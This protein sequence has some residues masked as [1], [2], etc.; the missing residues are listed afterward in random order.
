MEQK[1]RQNNQ[2]GIFKRIDLIMKNINCYSKCLTV[3][4]QW[5]LGVNLTGISEE[6]FF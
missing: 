3:V 4:F 1:L 5:D 2:Q 6:P